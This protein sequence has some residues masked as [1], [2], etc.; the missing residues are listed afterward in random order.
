M[1]WANHTNNNKFHFLFE[2]FK[3]VFITILKYKEISPLWVCTLSVYGGGGFV[4]TSLTPIWLWNKETCYE[5]TARRPPQ[6]HF[7]YFHL[8]SSKNST[9]ASL[10]VH[11]IGYQ[12][13][14]VSRELE[15]KRKIWP[16]LRGIIQL[17]VKFNIVSIARERCF[18]SKRERKRNLV[19]CPSLF[20]CIAH[21]CSGDS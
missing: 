17:N 12:S 3:R 18:G 1:W 8:H 10:C 16:K 7:W 21:S 9:T 4:G 20:L 11:D 13:G 15:M 2:S 6:W 5:I 14:K 19:S